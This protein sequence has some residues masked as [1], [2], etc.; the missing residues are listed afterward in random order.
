L[1]LAGIIIGT[2]GILD[3]IAV[4]QVAAVGEL[5][6]ANGTMP[7]RGIYH[8]AMRVGRSHLSAIINTL[9][10]AYAGTALPLLVLLHVNGNAAGTVINSEL[11]ATEIVRAV[12]GSLG[13]VLAMPIAT[14][15]AVWF[16]VKSTHPVDEPG[17]HLHV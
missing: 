10:M 1:L 4:S 7:K 11:I 15:V 2:L 17:G 8:A 12:V 6:R 9:I 14:L 5:R 13:L 3:D 16:N